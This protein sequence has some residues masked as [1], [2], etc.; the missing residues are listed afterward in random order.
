[1][2]EDK[3]IINTS[4]TIGSFLTGNVSDGEKTI[5]YIDCIG[6]QFK[7]SGALI[8]Y[9][10][11]ETAA[12]QMNNKFSNFFNE[13]TF[14]Y[15]TTKISN[16]KM[17][18]I[19]DYIKNKIEICKHRNLESKVSSSADEIVKFKKLLDDG[20]ITEEE[21]EAKKKQLLGI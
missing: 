1:M 11:L 7:Q 17:I 12:G 3:I 6:V 21:F 16:E 10:Q 5:Y 18:E 20:I 19:V 4:A 15:D 14:T 2:Y 13:N 8:G 9:I